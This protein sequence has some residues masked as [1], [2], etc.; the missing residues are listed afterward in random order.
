MIGRVPFNILEYTKPFSGIYIMAIFFGNYGANILN[1]T[2]AGD[3][4]QG[5]EGNDTLNGYGGTDFLFGGLGDDLL[6]SGAGEDF[7]EGGEGNDTLNG[8]SGNN[9]VW[10]QGGNDILTGGLGSD[11]FFF[12]RRLGQAGVDTITDFSIS[13]SDRI[14]LDLRVFTALETVVTD[15][16]AG[17]LGNNPLMEADFSVINVPVGGEHFIAGFSQDEIVYNRMTGS[18]FY[19]PNNKGL[20]FGA[21]GG[22]FATIVGS[23]DSLSTTDFHIINSVYIPRPDAS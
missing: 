17:I 13:D 4:M 7:L 3:H 18:L 23:P 21:G 14:V 10:G 19:N 12:E 22:K 2:E 16:Y 5:N 1:G 9:H 15:R 6:N 11:K 20:G 8:G